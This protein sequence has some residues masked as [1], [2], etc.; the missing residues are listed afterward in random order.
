MGQRQPLY[1]AIQK[2][3][4]SGKVQSTEEKESITV[5][6]MPT[7]LTSSQHSEGNPS[8]DV[9]FKFNS[10]EQATAVARILHY[11]RV[12][13]EE[14]ANEKSQEK[15]PYIADMLLDCSNLIN[16]MVKAIEEQTK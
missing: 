10:R 11:Q 13:L 8:V 1:A 7:N 16:D 3:N 5:T 2:S 15:Y 14:Q 6:D 12:Q 9:N 4:N